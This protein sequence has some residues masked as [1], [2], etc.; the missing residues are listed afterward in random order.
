TWFGLT[1]DP[2]E[3]GYISLEEVVNVAKNV[4]G[5]AHNFKF[6][7]F[8]LNQQMDASITKRNQKVNGE[9]FTVVEAAKNLGLL[10][11]TSAPFNLGKLIDKTK[12]A[13]SILLEVTQ[14]NEILS[15]MV[16]MKKIEHIKDNIQI[17][18]RDLQ[19]KSNF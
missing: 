18:K 17:F 11:T 4:A 15:T 3:E 2:G 9:W 16:G 12:V 19:L 5:D 10:S 1:N 7:Q 8:P 6:I 13:K 14:H